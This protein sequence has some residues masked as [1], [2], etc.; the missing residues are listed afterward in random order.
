MEVGTTNMKGSFLALLI[1]VTVLGKKEK[2]K[3]KAYNYTSHS[4]KL[5]S[6]SQKYICGY[7]VRILSHCIDSRS[8]KSISMSNEVTGKRSKL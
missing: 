8:L 7:F 3:E 5:K 4:S 2:E 1:D 6:L